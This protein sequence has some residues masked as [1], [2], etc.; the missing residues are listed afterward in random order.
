MIA[1]RVF[2]LFFSLV[3]IA[4]LLPLF[5]AIAAWIKLDSPGPIF[6]RQ[7]RIGQFG[8]EF[9]IYKFRTMVANA[10]ALGKQIT[11]THDQRI[12]RSGQFLRKY[13]LDELPQLFNVLKGEMSFVGPRPEVPKYVALYTTDQLRVLEVPPGITD[14]ASIQFR[15]EGDLLVNTPNPEEIYIQEI[16]PQKLELNRQYITQASLGFDL[17]LILKTL[18]QVIAV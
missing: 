15:N 17:L 11:A 9:T 6:F 1:K 10:E 4:I 14:L 13:K 8:H 18:W 5:V 7:I 12:T 2:D 3:S 16:M